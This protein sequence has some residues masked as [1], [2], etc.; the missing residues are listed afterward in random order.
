MK[1]QLSAYPAAIE[2]NATR[3]ASLDRQLAQ[4]K[5]AME[6]AETRVSLAVA[7]DQ[8]LK[9]DTQRKAR[10]ANALLTDPSYQQL[11]TELLNL[12]ATKA[13]CQA[14]LECLRNE[15]SIAKLELR[16][17]I[18]NQLTGIEAADLV[19]V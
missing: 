3:L 14:R 10:T 2:Q 9:N 13:E 6:L 5:Q 1:L 7:F 8:E 12:T 16:Q 19:G 18:A 4:T 17:A 15:M 11:Q